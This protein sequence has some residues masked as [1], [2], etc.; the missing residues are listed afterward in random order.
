MRVTERAVHRGG[1]GG[2]IATTLNAQ[3]VDSTLS[4]P[5]P[6]VLGGRHNIF[7]VEFKRKARNIFLSAPGILGC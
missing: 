2:S 4:A 7:K 1:F 6:A 3:G 5:P